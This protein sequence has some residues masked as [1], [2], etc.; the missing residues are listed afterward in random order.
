MTQGIVEARL[1]TLN[2][3]LGR[4]PGA[5]GSYQLYGAYGSWAI[6]RVCDD[7]RGD[8]FVTPLGTLWTAE[9]SA[10]RL[11]D[12]LHWGNQLA[13]DAAREGAAQ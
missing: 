2:S 3:L 8:H 11:V 6:H 1:C 10:D 5:G 4:Q 13:A 7:G 9:C 12:Y